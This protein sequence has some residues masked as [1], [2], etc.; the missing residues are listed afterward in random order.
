MPGVLPVIN[1]KAVEYTLLT[2]LALN[3]EIPEATKFDRKNYPYP[4]LVKGYQ[5]SQ[6]DLPLV[7]G[8]WL[9][10]TV[11]G[12]EPRTDPP[13]ARPPRRGHRQA[14][15]HTAGGSLVDFNRSGVPLMEIVSQPDLRSPAE[16]RAYLRSCARSCARS[17]SATPTWRRASSAATPTSRCGRSARRSSAPRSKSR[18]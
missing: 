15:A 10:I 9:E 3:A 6:Y 14:D 8:G 18:T 2:G 17:A 4:D 11:D 5:I 13:R 16:A 12:A 1:R 7:K